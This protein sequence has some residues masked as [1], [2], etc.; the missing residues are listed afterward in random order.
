VL[1]TGWPPGIG[2][3]TGRLADNW[4]GDQGYVGNGMITPYKKTIY[5]ELID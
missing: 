2:R 4:M 5:R 3:T 1:V